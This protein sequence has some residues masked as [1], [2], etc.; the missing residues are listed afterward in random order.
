MK[1]FKD[2]EF[3]MIGIHTPETAEERV[4]N[5]L[6]SAM[7]EAGLSF[8]ILVDNARQHWNAWGNTM[9][10]TVYL[11][12]KQ[13]YVRSWWMGELDWEGAGMQKVMQSR[14]RALLME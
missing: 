6:E 13:G 2:A 12:D 11:I 1:E 10:P 8:P 14:I 3:Q 9:W 5:N 4:V 7:K